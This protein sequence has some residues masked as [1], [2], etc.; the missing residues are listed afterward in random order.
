MTQSILRNT[1]TEHLQFLTSAGLL[2]VYHDEPDVEYS[3]ESGLLYESAY[4]SLVRQ[5]RRNL[6]LAVGEALEDLYPERQLELAPILAEH[7]HHAGDDRRALLYFTMAG[8][9]AMQMYANAEAVRHFSS[10]LALAKRL[11]RRGDEYEVE[12]PVKTLGDLYRKRGQALWWSGRYN[13]ALDNYREMEKVAR[14]R[15][16]KDMELACLMDLANLYSSPNPQFDSAQGET[17]ALQAQQLAR[18]LNNPEAEARILWVLLMNGFFSNQPKKATEYGE[19]SI[20]LARKHQLSEQLALTL[21]DMAKYVYTPQLKFEVALAALSE[22]KTIWRQL[23]SKPRISDTLLSEAIVYHN[24]GQFDHASSL[25]EEGTQIAKSIGSL[26]HMAF[27]W[28][29]QGDIYLELGEY[30]LALRILDDAYRTSEDS[31][32][33]AGQTIAFGLLS[34]LYGRMGA[35]PQALAY[36]HYAVKT[37]ESAVPFWLPQALGSLALLYINLGDLDQA[38]AVI[39][40]AHTSHQEHLLGFYSNYIPMAE[41]ELFMARQEYSRLLSLTDEILTYPE[42]MNARGILPYF[43]YY[44]GMALMGLEQLEDAGSS[45]NEAYLLA[46][47]HSVRHPLWK[48]S[49]NLADLSVK[50]DRPEAAQKYRHA[51]QEV[52][53]FICAHSGTSELRNKFLEQ[54]DVKSVMTNRAD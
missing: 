33:I 32:F 50:L 48:S 25:V 14:D 11:F 46:E 17:L 24:L 36:G 6:H 9:L 15:G 13:Q 1:I 42:S 43:L 4:S 30:E 44:R 27:G 26:W 20:E 39:D 45:L 3:F 28:V 40:R 23:D 18:S 12:G 41:C 22:A 52:I 54:P 49:A 34:V 19:Q 53:D 2:S 51:A 8:N 29:V 16:D 38:Q 21:N 35:L 10:A 47:Q 31:G 37:A 5:D 7:F